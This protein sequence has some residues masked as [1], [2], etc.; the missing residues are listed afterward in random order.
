MITLLGPAQFPFK[1]ERAGAA[2]NAAA[3]GAGG[4]GR[5][6]AGVNLNEA[7]YLDGLRRCPARAKRGGKSKEVR[8]LVRVRCM[9]ALIVLRLPCIHLSTRP[10]NPDLDSL[11]PL[12]E[13]A[14]I[15]GGR[16]G[17]REEGIEE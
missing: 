12:F 1:I 5:G 14:S 17:G 16:E 7:N 13:R 10:D 3:T 9:P 4:R 2:R 8:K 11:S 6:R 15:E